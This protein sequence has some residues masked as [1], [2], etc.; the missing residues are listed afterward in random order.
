LSAINRPF[1][2]ILTSSD[3]T[4]LWPRFKWRLV[5]V[6]SGIHSFSNFIQFYFHFIPFFALFSIDLRHPFTS[7]FSCLVFYSTFLCTLF[8][9]P[10]VQPFILNVSLPCFL[11]IS[12]FTA[13]H[14]THLSALFSLYSS[15]PLFFL[16]V[17]LLDYSSS[18]HLLHFFT[19]VFPPRLP[20][21]H[22]NSRRRRTV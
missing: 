4:N 14:F 13:F 2:D 5:S 16:F 7:L 20:H 22:E 12:S 1:S 18:F 3:K 21:L 6:L 8:P 15:C 11:F 19:C 9:L 17:A 10:S